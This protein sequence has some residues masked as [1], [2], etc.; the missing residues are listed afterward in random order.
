MKKKVVTE[1]KC[2][3]CE[4]PIED[5]N[6]AVFSCNV[7]QDFWKTLVPS[8]A[9]NPTAKLFDLVSQICLMKDYDSLAIFCSLAWGFWY[10]RNKMAFE[11]VVLSTKQVAK[12]VL[13]L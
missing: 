12:H 9:M 6:H 2:S 3:F 5:L 1:G 13:V 11:N 4:Y 10:R 7:L 8:L